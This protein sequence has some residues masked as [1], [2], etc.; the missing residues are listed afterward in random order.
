MSDRPLTE[1]E[2]A[3]LQRALQIA[4]GEQQQ[5]GSSTPMAGRGGQGRADRENAGAAGL[6][7][8]TGVGAAG[9]STPS[10]AAA[11]RGSGSGSSK[12]RLAQAGNWCCLELCEVRRKTSKMINGFRVYNC[13][14]L[15]FE[16]SYGRAA[17]KL[18]TIHQDARSEHGALFRKKKMSPSSVVSWSHKFVCLDKT[19]ADRV[20]TTQS[21]KMALEEAGLGEKTILLPDVDCDPEDFHTLI[22]GTYPKLREGGGYELLRCK[23]AS[24][25]L[26]IIGPRISNTPKLLK[27]RV[28][29]G[30]VYLRPL[31]RDLGL[32]EEDC[33]E[34]KGVGNT[35]LL[36]FCVWQR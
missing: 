14:F 7:E 8:S 21:A 29:N 36:E 2:R 34:V 5:P 11:I 27:R 24:R 6:G 26:I 22:L 35:F 28:G 18:R 16:D 32:E 10:R 20:P 19:D 30:K 3:I 17:S 13:C 4:C 9:R 23:P 15:G 31:Q 1:A 33:D 12:L 25:D